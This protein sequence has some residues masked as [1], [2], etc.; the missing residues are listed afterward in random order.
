MKKNGLKII[1]IVLAAILL[2]VAGILVVHYVRFSKRTY[3]T[4]EVKSEI[5][6]TGNTGASFLTGTGIV[7]RYTRDG[8]SG[9]GTN[10]KE[11]WNVSY[12]MS[13]PV[14]DVCGT[15]AA[16]ADK[17][18]ENLYILDGT[19]NVHNITTEHPVENVEVADKGITAVWMDDGDKDYITLYKVDG[20]KI[21]DIMTTAADDG[22][23][24]AIGLSP[25]GSKLVTSYAVFEENHLKNQV[26]FYNFSDS[27]SN[28]VDRLVGLKTYEDRLVADIEFA[29]EDMVVCFSD[30]G[31]NLFEMDVTEAEKKEIK[32]EDTIRQVSVSE[33]YIGVVTLSSSGERKVTV[34]KPD[35]SVKETKKLEENYDNFMLAGNDIIFFA[36]TKLYITRLNGADKITTDVGMDIEAVLP[37]DGKRTF[38]IVGEQS[39]K[40]IELEVSE[41]N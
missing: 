11:K 41:K 17:G 27:G 33:D 21:A 1:A 39:F 20:N 23:P 26:T 37:V 16:V 4:F 7:V 34:Y 3:D 36:G 9:F 40:I 5:K 25:D 30:A 15:Y 31:I 8:V 10:G 2:V 14:A 18:S 13:N 6:N 29:G 35:G 32:I 24:V 12:E 38:M 22:V 28:Y 19:G